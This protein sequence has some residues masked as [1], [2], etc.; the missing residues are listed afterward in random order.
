MNDSAKKRIKGNFYCMLNATLAAATKGR[1]VAARLCLGEED[2]DF[3]PRSTLHT[4]FSPCCKARG[5][6]YIRTYKFHLIP[7]TFICFSFLSFHS[8]RSVCG[9]FYIYFISTNRLH[10]K[11]HF[12]NLNPESILSSKA[13][14]ST[15]VAT[16]KVYKIFNSSF[17][18]LFL[19]LPP[20][21]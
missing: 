10:I 2:E 4:T 3:H 11:S 17:T 14:S 5:K 8:F 1:E 6:K 13:H 21:L 9:K 7:P 19:S 20:T 16:A 18:F 12:S 15:C